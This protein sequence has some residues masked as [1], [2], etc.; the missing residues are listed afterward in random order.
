MR[1]GHRERE[2]E[3]ERKRQTDREKEREKETERESLV[4]RKEDSSPARQRVGLG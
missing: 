1:G 4:R 2:R 3:R